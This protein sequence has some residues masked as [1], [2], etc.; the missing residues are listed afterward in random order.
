MTTRIPFKRGD[1]FIIEAAVLSG[2]VAQDI[3]GWTVRSQVRNGTTLV[4]EL[5][6]EYIDRAAGTYRLRENDTTGWPTKTLQWDIEYTTDAGQIASTETL[7]I[8]VKPDITLP[9]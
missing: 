7:E 9:V 6:V 5:A 2:A 4:S 8:L 3:T 1:T